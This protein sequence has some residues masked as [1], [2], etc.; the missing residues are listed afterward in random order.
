MIKGIDSSYFNVKNCCYVGMFLQFLAAV[1]SVGY[2]NP[3][4]HWQ[5]LEFAAYKLGFAPLSDMP[6]EVAAKSRQA[7]L[8]FFAFCLGKIMLFFDIYNPFR[9]IFLL[10]LC[11]G[12][13]AY[14]SMMLLV[15]RF[16][17]EF[18][19]EKSFKIVVFLA[20]FLWFIPYI[21]TRFQSENWTGI[22]L[23][24]AVYFLYPTFKN[25]K[26]SFVKLF[27]VGFLLGVAFIIRIQSGLAIFGIGLWLFFYSRIN[28]ISYLSL[29]IGFCLMCAFGVLIDYWFYSS[30]VFTPYT[31][32]D[33]QVLQS[34]SSSWGIYPWWHY[35]YIFVIQVV[36]PESLVLLCLLLFS[37]LSFP[38][39]VFSWI[40]IFFLI[41]H[42]YISYKEIRYLY[43]LVSFFVI[44]CALGLSHFRFQIFISKINY[45]VFSVILILLLFQNTIFLI[46]TTLKPSNEI[47]NVQ[48]FLYESAE[49]QPV[50]VFVNGNDSPFLWGTMKYNFY[51]HPN[52]SVLNI[53]NAS[54]IL[55]TNQANTTYYFAEKYVFLSENFKSDKIGGL[56]FNTIPIWLTNFN[57]TNWL[58]RA[59]VWTVYEIKNE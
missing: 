47:V 42:S 14:S 1:F 13:L 16:K 31:Y 2:H 12:I 34:M 24:F 36:P 6:W 56:V 49:K 8:P 39:H 17:N 32:F 22:F 28:F 26:Q 4:E 38:K 15:F 33:L 59:R 41:G 5:L 29:A 50:V 58:S 51:S 25:E 21:H 48:K 20:N 18:P 57:F 30:W 3:D 27:L 54:Q 23:T 53:Q 46:V 11:S 52:I 35:F 44:I 37:I 45:K 55:N 19:T 7:I 43:P 10:R 9:L 40:I